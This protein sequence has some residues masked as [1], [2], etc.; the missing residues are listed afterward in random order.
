MRNTN[1]AFLCEHPE[2]LSLLDALNALEEFFD[3]FGF[4]VMGRDMILCKQYA[5]SLQIIFNSA[6]ATLGSII[7]CCKCYC[8]ADAYTL[9]RKY[10]D[11]LFFCLYLV[12]YNASSKSEATETTKEV[13]NSIE[14]WCK[15]N[16]SNLKISKVLSTISST[17]GLQEAIK[18]YSLRESFSKIGRKLNDYVHG[19]GYTYYNT[20]VCLLS[21][22]SI[23]KQLE[24]LTCTARYTTATFLFLLALCSPQYIM[25]TDYI[26]Y[27]EMGQVP[28]DDS[29]YWVAPFIVEFLKNNIA[30]ID[31]NCYQ[32]LK[33][34]IYM[35][36]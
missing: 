26:D 13:E 3:D 22:K 18:K 10:R 15:N 27:L 12:V 30:L 7:E 32:Y 33:E 28:P 25:A 29:Q 20:N 23:E 34:N 36:L 31:Q 24:E 8:L 6:Q 21:G 11:D 16:L 35:A 14:R 9:L 2:Y 5:F 4:L 1:K 19:N 17:D